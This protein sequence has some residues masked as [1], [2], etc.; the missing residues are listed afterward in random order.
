MVTVAVAT[1][2]NCLAFPVPTASSLLDTDGA[3]KKECLY[4]RCSLH[5]ETLWRP[6]TLAH[7]VISFFLQGSAKEKPL[8]A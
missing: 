7:L 3:P 4:D 5:L 8:V 6:R 2:P 1:G